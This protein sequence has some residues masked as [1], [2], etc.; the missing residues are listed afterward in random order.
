MDEATN[1]LV[2]AGGGTAILTA[3]WPGNDNWNP[4][5]ATL[6]VNVNAD[7]I[8]L[9]VMGTRV[10]HENKADILGDGKVEYDSET[11]T[12]TLHSVNWELPGYSSDIKYGVIEFWGE[13]GE[14][15]E[16]ETSSD[17]ASISLGENDQ[18]NEET[19]QLEI[20]STLT[21]EE[22]S[23]ALETFGIGSEALKYVM[24]GS[25]H[26]KLNPGSGKI[27]L[28]CMTID[29]NQIMV[30]I[31]D[32]DP[33]SIIKSA[34][35]IAEIE[36][37]ADEETP[38]IIFVNGQVGIDVHWAPDYYRAPRED[39]TP[40]MAAAIKSIAVVPEE[41]ASTA[42]ETVEQKEVPCNKIFRNGQLLI[43]RGDKT[44]TLTGAEIR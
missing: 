27:E 29:G 41:N 14:G 23:T 5:Y 40:Q 34:M 19:E 37:E 26:F 6:T 17:I 12:L 25:I 11:Q 13:G 20:S 24:P 35:G 3:S 1:R 36:Y 2:I 22:V 31:G 39:E 33:V 16:T 9:T 38:V 10:T 18:Y 8:Y 32:E 43:L 4:A 44:Y 15:A 30:K 42:I 28:E 21:A 7:P